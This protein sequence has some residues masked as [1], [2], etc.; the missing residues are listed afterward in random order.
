M[1]VISVQAQKKADRVENVY[2]PKFTVVN[3]SAFSVIGNDR[4]SNS[5]DFTE[6]DIKFKISRSD[7]T[8]PVLLGTKYT[9]AKYSGYTVR[10]NSGSII[11]TILTHTYVHDGISKYIKT[12]LANNISMNA[13]IADK[14]REQQ[15]YIDLE[16]KRLSDVLAKSRKIDSKYL[17]EQRERGRAKFVS[18]SLRKIE[19]ERIRKLNEQNAK[20]QELDK[21]KYRTDRLTAN[22]YVPTSEIRTKTYETKLGAIVTYSYYMKDGEEVLHGKYTAK[23]IYKDY[24]FWG[25]WVNGFIYL[26]GIE[27]F[28]CTYKNGVM[29]GQYKYSRDVKQES[30]FGNEHDFKHSITLNIWNGFLDG[31]FDFV[32]D[33]FRY[34]GRANHGILEHITVTKI[35]NSHSQSFKSNMNG[36]R[37]KPLILSF[38]GEFSQAFYGTEIAYFGLTVPKQTIPMPYVL[39]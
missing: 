30:T 17:A 9:N 3:I 36:D 39:Q 12:K 27:T 4:I 11:D 28:E 22:F 25:T 15:E 2:L 19:D 20:Q 35:S 7:D 23:H 1:S 24:K 31:Q 13:Y 18:D 21:W 33:E 6:A 26:N 38:N 10:D 34:V 29:H 14:L 16:T 37:T 5:L 8:R 32:A